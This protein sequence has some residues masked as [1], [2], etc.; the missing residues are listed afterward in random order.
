MAGGSAG[1]WG[2]PGD[3]GRSACE[4]DEASGLR[5]V[6]RA[7]SERGFHASRA[8]DCSAVTSA[9]QSRGHHGGDRHASAKIVELE[10]GLFVVEDKRRQ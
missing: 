7:R 1:Y 9:S 3:G 6:E 10:G 2:A 8:G 4:L 5:R